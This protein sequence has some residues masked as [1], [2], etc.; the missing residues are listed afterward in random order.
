MNSF[1]LLIEKWIP[2]ETGGITEKISLKQLLCEDADWEISLY[3]DDMELATIQMLVSMVQVIFMPEDEDAL[4]ESYED[5][6]DSEQYDKGVTPFLDWF[7]LLHKETPFMQTSSAKA[8]HS[9]T[10]QKF[11]VGLPEGSSTSQ[12]SNGFFNQTNEVVNLILGETAI[13][14]FQQA[15]NGHGLGGASFSVGLKGLM[16]LTTL[17]KENKLRET[18]WV[19]V[20][21]KSYLEEYTTLLTGD[22]EDKPTWV[23]APSFDKNKPENASRIGLLRGLF[24]QPAKILLNIKDG[25]TVDFV[26]EPNPCVLNGFW[27]HPHTPID[28]IRFKNNNPKEKPFLSANKDFPL[29]QNMM[30]FLYTRNS[31]EQGVSRAIVVSSYEQILGRGKNINLIVG[32][33]VKGGSTESLAGRKHETYSLN[34]GWNQ[35]KEEIGQLIDYALSAQKEL[36]TGIYNFGRNLKLD[37]K[38]DGQEKSNLIKKHLQPKAKNSYFLNS[39]SIMHSILRRL[40]ITD[41]AKYKKY[42]VDLAR[43]TFDD[44]LAP[45]EHDSKYLKAIVQS[46]RTLLFKLKEI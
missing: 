6:M 37:G 1:N 38:S 8:K 2:V 16:P 11:F 33:Y 39:E 3:R 46:R 17:V 26:K 14:I 30:S 32:G 36:N 23:E 12:S 35:Q 4:I 24:W 18:I 42:F 5:L 29:W 27:H 19:N 31:N 21:D 20:L 45:Y 13:A 40:K 25:L 34:T 9:T 15:T 22:K 43:Q 41:V 28:L 7:D 44:I 10:L